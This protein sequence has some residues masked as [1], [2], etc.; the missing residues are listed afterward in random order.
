MKRPEI[1]E[2]AKKFFGEGE[3]GLGMKVGAEEGAQIQFFGNGLVWITVWPAK[4]GD[5]EYRVDLDVSE[6]DD[7][8]RKFIE[9][10]LKASR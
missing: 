1:F 9:Q 4:Q 10:V 6:R 3:G 5:K 8:A 7:D 2:A